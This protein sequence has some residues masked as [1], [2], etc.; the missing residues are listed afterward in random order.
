[1]IFIFSAF[2]QKVLLVKKGEE[3]KL[4]LF[5]LMFLVI[6]MGVEMGS[7]VSMALFLTNV[8]ADKLPIMFM[9]AAVLNF[10][11]VVSYMYV[12]SSKNNTTLFY[13]L[14]GGAAVIL[15]PARIFYPHF[16][17]AMSYVFYIVFEFL[18]SSI[19]L[20]FT[21]YLSD[22]FDTRESKR[23]FPIIF[24]G[25]RLGGILGGLVLTF[26]SPVVGSVNIIII[27][28][29]TLAGAAGLLGIISRRFPSQVFDYEKS[30]K[31]S[32]MF[33][34]HIKSGVKLLRGS[35]LLKSLAAGLFLLGS[36]SLV[37]KFLYSNVFLQTFPQQNQ[38]T[39]FYG[40]YIIVANV[41]GLI[42][43]LTL[44][45]RLIDSL[46]LG[47]SNTLYAVSFA[48]G[49]LVLVLHY[50]FISALWAR[51]SDEQLES[52]LQD[53]VEG[54][55]FNA[56]PDHERARAKAISSGMIKPLSE[57]TGSIILQSVKGFL[58]A[59]AIA[60]MGLLMAG[61]YIVVSQLQNKG[62][63]EGLMKMVRDKTLNLDDLENL[64]WEKASKK[65]LEELYK[66]ASS[67]DVSISQSAVTL[68]L[69][70]DEEID[71]S[72]MAGSFFQWKPETQEEFLRDYFRRRTDFDEALLE[73]A[74]VE[75]SSNVKQV[76]I[77]YFIEVRFGRAADIIK[78]FLHQQDDLELQ[79]IAVRYLVITE[80]PGKEEAR[81]LLKKRMESGEK[82]VIL[83]NLA[84]IRELYDEVHLEY[85]KKMI[86]DKRRVVRVEAVNTLAEIYH[87]RD[88]DHPEILKLV[89]RLISTGAYHETRAAV[90]ILGKRAGA[91]EKQTLVG[92]LENPM[93]I[94]REQ[95]IETLVRNYPEDF[96]DYLELLESPTQSL[97]LKENLIF[98]I[99][100][101]TR[102][103]APYR[104]RL[105][106]ILKGLVGNYFEC[107]Q[108]Q[109]TL[110]KMGLEESFMIELILRSKTQ[111]RMMILNLL[112]IL[113]HQKVLISIEKALITR[114]PRLISNALELF[115]NLWEK[116]Q[117]K[118]L[119]SLI[120]PADFQEE[121]DAA[122]E[123][124]GREPP[125]FTSL[126]EKYLDPKRPRWNICAALMLIKDD[127]RYEI[128][129]D[130]TLFLDHPDPLVQEITRT[131]HEKEA[132][133]G[134][135][136]QM[137]TTI[138][139]VI[140]LKSAPL[141][142]SLKMDELKVIADICREKVYSDGEIIIEKGDV[143]F[144]MFIIADGEVEIFLPGSPH[145]TLVIL[146]KS[147]FF[148]EMALFG[149]DVRS[150]SAKAVSSAVKLLCIDR[151]HFLNLIYEKPD[152]SVEIIK[153][154]SDRIRRLETKK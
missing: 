49:F 59:K 25:S 83:A 138:E 70:L 8:G 2:L 148:G 74:L 71:F 92:L 99:Q 23:L 144:T 82:E 30:S 103:H 117:T 110:Q 34:R 113:L 140:Y 128:D 18:F 137:L 28:I 120:Y 149:T 145:T 124:T 154:L 63:V 90:K 37:I 21:T 42:L 141:F 127:G 75:C 101:L 95:I 150:A 26:F 44:V 108:E 142:K 64:R 136:A 14:I 73:K 16:P 130:T 102:K 119:V 76:V 40:I 7:G 111:L 115:E 77:E 94:L 116:K 10:G 15:L 84:V 48:S 13:M 29:A 5:L 66:M 133:E 56:V 80:F 96:E 50:D 86:M 36:L 143:G 3:K 85:L 93:G 6:I 123:F 53:P 60:F 131:I 147:D 87:P 78:S 9:I 91:G 121:L 135:P 88:K 46:G 38:L 62:Y 43:Q 152:I 97:T 100:K 125:S 151:D 35:L 41:L 65:D 114:N 39:A 1:M 129:S 109:D 107:I 58:N 33:F 134:R 47:A 17:A 126:M 27:W 12:S 22:Y 31:E 68:L 153:V 106:G 72:R 51:F 79:N 98:L 105:M 19:N 67:E 57:I 146:K 32:T 54:L 132:K 52:V 122:K 118:H 69:N 112:G 11:V 61:L 81:E 4:F 24:C 20:H 104:E 55:F 139:K 89:D 45:N